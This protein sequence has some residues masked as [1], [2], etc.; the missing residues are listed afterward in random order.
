[1][2]KPEDPRL[3]LKMILIALTAVAALIGAALLAVP[4]AQ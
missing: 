1:M 4:S 2:M 3:T